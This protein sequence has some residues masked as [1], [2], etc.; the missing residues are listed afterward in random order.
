M[1]EVET[2]FSDWLVEKGYVTSSDTAYILKT[3]ENGQKK[4]AE[5]LNSDEKLIAEEA[6]KQYKVNKEVC[7]T[8][9]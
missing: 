2:N 9:C 8:F 3:F 4:F 6:A 5:R 7:S 1:G